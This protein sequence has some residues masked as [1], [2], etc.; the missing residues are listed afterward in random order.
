MNIY[1][2]LSKPNTTKIGA[3]AIAWWMGKPYSHAYIRFESSDPD[4]PSNVYQASHGM[5]HFLTLENFE[6]TNFR[7]KEY[8]IPVSNE[9]RKK[10]LIRCMKL[11]GVKYSYAELAK[12]FVSDVANYLGYSLKFQN[13]QGYICSELV[14]DLS[15]S[16]GIAYQKSCFLLKPVD[17]DHA[18]EGKFEVSRGTIL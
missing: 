2:G 12:I 9:I 5:C 7:V 17:I 8:V 3:E 15:G 16:L 4:I 13:S 1:V 14:G 6:Q 18:L 11:A 10:V